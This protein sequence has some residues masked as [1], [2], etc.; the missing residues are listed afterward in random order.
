MPSMTLPA[1]AAAAAPKRKLSFAEMF[2]TA[3]GKSQL[4]VFVLVSTL[5]G[6]W[7]FCNGQLEVLNRQFQNSLHVT[8]AANTE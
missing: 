2:R 1:E 8:I 5:S 7:G 4:F 3:D 6:L